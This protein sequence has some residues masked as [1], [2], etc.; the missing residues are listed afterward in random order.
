MGYRGRLSPCLEKEQELR[1]QA[2]TPVVDYFKPW[3]NGRMREQVKGEI[4]MG[5]Q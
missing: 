3:V 4:P 1:S 5:G 2:G